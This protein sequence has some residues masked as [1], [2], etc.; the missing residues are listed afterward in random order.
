MIINPELFLGEVIISTEQTQSKE[1]KA[2]YEI[3]F[4]F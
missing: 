1:N 3:S 4:E 2:K